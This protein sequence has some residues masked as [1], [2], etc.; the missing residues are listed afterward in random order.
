MYFV[1]RENAIDNQFGTGL[2]LV[3]ILSGIYVKIINHSII[4]DGNDLLGKKYVLDLRL[5]KII[6]RTLLSIRDK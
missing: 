5:L 6:G 3:E 2:V 1:F 4:Q